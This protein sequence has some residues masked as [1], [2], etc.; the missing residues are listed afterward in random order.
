MSDFELVGPSDIDCSK[1]DQETRLNIAVYL[2]KD[3][4]TRFDH[5]IAV[6]SEMTNNPDRSI[7]I[8]FS[9]GLPTGAYCNTSRNT[10][11]SLGVCSLIKMNPTDIAFPIHH[12]QEFQVFRQLISN[13]LLRVFRTSDNI[14]SAMA[15]DHENLAMQDFTDYEQ[16]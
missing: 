2:T 16:C 7:T 13:F 15:Y 12:G 1:W 11:V 4:M 3:Q 10:T 9:D 8:I 5:E 6:A 14:D